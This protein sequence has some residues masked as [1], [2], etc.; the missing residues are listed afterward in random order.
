MSYCNSFKDYY[1]IHS[2]YLYMALPSSYIENTTWLRA[3]LELASSV[4]CDKSAQIE[5]FV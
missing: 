3:R 5:K 4:D 2:M 1:Q